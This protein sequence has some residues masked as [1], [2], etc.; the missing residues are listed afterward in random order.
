MA[1][2]WILKLENIEKD[3]FFH[4]QHGTRIVVFDGF[5]HLFF[6]GQ[7]TILSG[8]SG[9][10]KS[11]LLR[12]I[13]GTYKTGAGHIWV[14]HRGRP[15]DI[16][17]AKPAM[18]YSLRRDTIGYV[19]QFLRVIPRV[20][21]LDTVIEPLLARNTD[22]DTAR[23]KGRALLERLNIPSNMWHLSATTFSGGEQQRINLAKG[24]IA[25]FP[26]LLLDEP[27]AS[28]DLKN[29][30][31]VIELIKEALAD[32]SCVIGVF[33]D[34]ADHKEFAGHTI[35]LSSPTNSLEVQQPCP[36]KN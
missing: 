33:H 36:E 21:A 24:F 9:T 7:A 3:F 25:P 14:R 12:M 26:V 28:L 35:E 11:T 8:P 15:L 1:L 10:G 6:P 20:S 16:A 5:S 27:T 30:R 17:A 23:K 22:P 29:R 18:I 31:I 2:H 32:N 34:P 4:L 13:Y 19:S